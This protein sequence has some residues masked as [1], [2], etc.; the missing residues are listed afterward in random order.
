MGKCETPM[1]A[2]YVYHGF[3]TGTGPASPTGLTMNR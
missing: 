3:Q 1:H 2:W